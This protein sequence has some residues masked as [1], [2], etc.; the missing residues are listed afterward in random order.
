MPHTPRT[1]QEELRQSRPF[2]SQAVELLV[3]LY[4][5]V[6]L[7]A[8]A[9]REGLKAF[10]LSL[11][12]YNVLRILAG[13][14]ESGHRVADIG[15]RLITREPDVTRLVDGLERKGLVRRARNKEDRRV[16]RVTLT[17][18]GSRLVREASK[19]VEALAARQFAHLSSAEQRTLIELLT[20]VRNA[21]SDAP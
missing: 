9:Q 17:A 10:D 19:S 21:P 11:T 6:D 7:V 3:G 1:L 20:A 14:G 12:Q 15:E 4:R 2:P 5:T 8:G 13:A 16:V 18:A